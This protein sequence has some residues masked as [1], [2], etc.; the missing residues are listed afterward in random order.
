MPSRRD[1]LAA[2]A[3]FVLVAIAF[4]PAVR[5][6][7]G[8]VDDP[9]YVTENVHVRAGL[10]PEGVAWAFTSMEAANWHPLTWLSHAFDWQL[11]G[12]SAGGHHASNLLLH[13]LN[14]GLLFWVLWR[15]TGSVG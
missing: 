2:L 12:S 7:F 3:L 8:D 10:R 6:G 1:A 5:N 4:S 11:F 9:D 14:A 13:M 15:A